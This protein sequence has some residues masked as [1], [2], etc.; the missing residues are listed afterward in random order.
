MIARD[1][2]KSLLAQQAAPPVEPKPKKGKKAP[3][4]KREL[5]RD[6]TKRVKEYLELRGWRGVR[7]QRT[8]IPS[9]F[10]SGEP[11]QADFLFVRY[12][13]LPDGNPSAAVDLIWIE[14]KANTGHLGPKQVAWIER[15]K[16]R[17]AVVEVVD[18]PD[19]FKIWYEATFGVTGQM[20]LG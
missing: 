4:A 12:K 3:S 7:F 13:K 19:S 20:R 14:F 2:L 6:V 9:Q 8:V 16:G 10:Q 18:D 11:G 15:E 17:G 1:T 5:E